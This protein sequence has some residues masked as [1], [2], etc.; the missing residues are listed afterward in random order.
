MNNYMKVIIEAIKQWVNRQLI[1]LDEKINN[2]VDSVDGKVLSTNDYTNEEKEK[3][4]GI[5]AGA[6]R[7]TVN[8]Q[9]GDVVIEIPDITAPRTELILTSS[10]SGS[11]KQFKLTIDDDGVLT[12]TEIV[13]S[14]T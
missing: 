14:A 7:T 4:A 5:E 1:V 11:S 10:T 2:K 8:G 13:E 3:L 6:T 12:A 9:T